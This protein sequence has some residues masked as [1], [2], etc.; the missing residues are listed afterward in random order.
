MFIISSV[1][2]RCLINLLFALFGLFLPYLNSHFFCVEVAFWAFWRGFRP[3][4]AGGML[5]LAVSSGLFGSF[6]TLLFALF[7]TFFGMPF[8]LVFW[9]FSRSF[10]PCFQPFKIVTFDL[11]PA[12]LFR[13]F[14][15]S[16]RNFLG[17]SW[18]S[19]GNVLGRS[20]SRAFIV[21]KLLWDCPTS[22]LRLS[23]DY[24]G[25]I[26]KLGLS[27]SQAPVCH[28]VIENKLVWDGLWERP[29][30]YPLFA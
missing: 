18:H 8:C 7:L 9:P 11:F 24:L 12:A 20:H 28:T 3:C 21:D 14:S 5:L 1:R 13:S 6:S 19:P 16:P 23:W 4:V 27:Q 30:D 17:M 22:V 10:L 26:P 25:T 15:S 2:F 29:W